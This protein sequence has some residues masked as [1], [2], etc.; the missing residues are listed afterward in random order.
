MEAAVSSVVSV[1]AEY[2]TS[3]ANRLIVSAVRIHGFIAYTVARHPLDP[4]ECACHRGHT[5][6][7]FSTRARWRAGC[8]SSR[9][10]SG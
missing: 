2:A 6:V 10:R 8:A 5:G 9:R 3:S 1:E 7:T 4:L